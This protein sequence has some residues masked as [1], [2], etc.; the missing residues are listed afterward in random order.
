MFIV[1][2]RN[3][4]EP[5]VWRN[6]GPYC[7]PNRSDFGSVASLNRN[8]YGYEYRIVDTIKAIREYGIKLEAVK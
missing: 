7:L 1:I 4:T 8:N 6:A 5:D 2:S 3:K